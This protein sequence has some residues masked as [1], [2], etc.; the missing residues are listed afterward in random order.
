MQMYDLNISVLLMEKG[1]SVQR[2]IFQSILFLLTKKLILIN[3]LLV[4]LTGGELGNLRLV[5]SQL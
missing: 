3:T 4:I 5:L 1:K 2:R